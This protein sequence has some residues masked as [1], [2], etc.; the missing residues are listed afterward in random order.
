MKSWPRIN[1]G[2]ELSFND[3]LHGST[4]IETIT[5]YGD[6]IERTRIGRIG[7][8]VSLSIHWQIGKFK[9]HASVQHS[10]YDME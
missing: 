9:N 7:R 1:L 10:S 6:Y 5:S 3:L 8:S 4:G 2:G